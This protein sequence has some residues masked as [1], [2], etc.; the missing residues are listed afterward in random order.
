MEEKEG[1]RGY[2]EGEE[3]R[4]ADGP[5]EADLGDEVLD[6]GGEED[7]PHP[8]ARGRYGERE[9]PVRVEVGVDD[10]EG[11]HEHDAEAEAGAEALGEEELPVGRRETRHEGSEDDQERA[12]CDGGADVAGVGEAPGKC[13]SEEGE[14]RLEGAYPRDLRLGQ[15][16]GVAV[17]QLINA[18]G[19]WK[20]PCQHVD[21]ASG[22][23]LGPGE[24]S[25][26]W[27]DEFCWAGTG[28]SCGV[29]VEV[30]RGL[31]VVCGRAAKDDAFLGVWCGGHRE[32][33]GGLVQGPKCLWCQNTKPVRFLGAAFASAR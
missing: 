5:G 26:I 4:G 16:E 29:F 18:K 24:Q 23:D 1:E 33:V 14:G 2:D 11:R 28:W 21:K 20:T 17:V 25:S 30:S 22:E 3:A 12:G 8:V 32:S 13:A 9:G 15:A 27:G 10:G 6:C 19:C 31:V 7:A